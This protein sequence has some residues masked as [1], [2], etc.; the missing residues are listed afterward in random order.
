[1]LK[2]LTC[3]SSITCSVRQHNIL[4]HIS[5]HPPGHMSS[6][7]QPPSSHVLDV[8][9]M[10]P[11]CLLHHC[12]LHTTH[13]HTHRCTCIH[14]NRS[15]EGT[16]ASLSSPQYINPTYTD[17]HIRRHTHR[18]IYRLTHTLQTPYTLDSK[19]KRSMM[20]RGMMNR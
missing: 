18:H 15:T 6:Y 17:T 16:C 9:F 5:C 2:A 7:P 14:P 3:C 13:T 11:S 12:H 8:L 19:G 10:S 20:K 1:M 4:G